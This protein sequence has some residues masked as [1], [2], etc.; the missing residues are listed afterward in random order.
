MKRLL[1]GEKNVDSIF[2]S[3]LHGHTGKYHT[4]F[5]TISTE[6]PEAVFL[7]GDILPN[8]M[9]NDVN[10]FLNNVLF[11]KIEQVKKEINHDLIFFIILGNDDP[12]IFEEKLIE[13][14]QQG[15]ITYIHNRTVKYKN[16]YICGYSFIPPSP[17]QLKDWERYDVSRHVDVGAI[18]PERGRRTVNVPADQ[19]RYAT[20]KK[21]LERLSTSSPPDQTIY[22]FHSPPYDSNLDRASLDGKMVDYAPVDVHVG[23][24][25]IMRFIEEKQPF[26][27]LHGHVHESTRLTGEWKQKFGK[28][29]SFNGAHDGKDLCVIRFD[30]QYLDKATRSIIPMD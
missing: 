16:E 22:L 8:P 18:S 9:K 11:S 1:T 2:V 3:D 28:T 23:S 21:D 27:T 19:K 24:I 14:D 30:T 29:F 5:K 17:F 12:R 7:G 25:A 15:I 26:L 10:D 6:K 4:L 13:A 20:I